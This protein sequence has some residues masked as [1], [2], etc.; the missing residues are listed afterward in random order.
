MCMAYTI[1]L[2]ELTKSFGAVPVLTGLDLAVEAGSVVALLG[3]NGAGKTTT[4]R[5]LSTLLRAGGGSARV[6]G[7][8]VASEPV[9]V[10]EALSLTGQYAAVDEVLTGRENLMLM[11][12]LR[13]LPRTAAR[14]RTTELIERFGL[15]EACDRRVATYSGGMKRRLD[16]ALSLVSQPQVVV[17]DE[18]TTGLDPRSRREVWGAVSELAASGATVLLTTQY[19]EEADVLADRVAVIDGGRVVAEGS[20]D[21]LKARLGD[22]TVEL[23]FADPAAL[24][25][26][27]RLVDGA[28]ERER[29]CLRVPSDGSA[30]GVRRLLELIDGAERIELHRPT[31]DDVFL[32][33][34]AERV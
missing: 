21:E 18:P 8:D 27:A 14:R 9:K 4:V 10:R 2:D 16:L 30:A 15:E 5:I 29:L 1:E 17:L 34:T 24:D 12:R 7:F 25:E 33:L 11:A 19:L 20:A 28:V 6:A 13:H 26:A 23:F 32:S 31:L 22:E 3:A